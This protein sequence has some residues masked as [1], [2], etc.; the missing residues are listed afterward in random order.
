MSDIGAREQE[1]LIRNLQRVFRAKGDTLSVIDDVAPKNKRT[2]IA[3]LDWDADSMAPVMRK[4][5]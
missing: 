1:N 3:P 5:D 4:N 2:A